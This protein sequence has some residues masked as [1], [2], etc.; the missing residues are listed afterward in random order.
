MG[1]TPAERQRAY[2]KRRAERINAMEPIPCKCGC[3]T[4]IRPIT[5]NGTPALYA[6]GHNPGG[7]DTQFKPGR[8][9]P[10]DVEERRIANMARGPRNWR[11][12]GY[13]WPTRGGYYRR[14]LTP[15]EAEIMPTVV[16]HGAHKQPS[17]MRS[18]YVWNLNNQD[19]PVQPGE[20]IHH[21]NRMR[22]D[23]RI[24]NLQ[25]LSSTAEHNALH[26]RERR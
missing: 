15:S 3:G 10:P 13:E 26:A 20:V 5:T 24:E 1:M 16:R 21:I 4:G 9:L 19:D 6:W 8:V 18:H 17:I 23:D 25:K 12:T 14:T 2:R 22:D 7:E 11:Y